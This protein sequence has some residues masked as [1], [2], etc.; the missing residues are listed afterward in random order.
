MIFKKNKTKKKTNF[1]FTFLLRIETG[2]YPSDEFY[3]RL[4]ILFF[5]TL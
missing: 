3:P 2:A 5:K 4:F 1:E